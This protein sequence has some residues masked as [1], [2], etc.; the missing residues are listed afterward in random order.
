[1]QSTG[2]F[3]AMNLSKFCNFYRQ[4]SITLKAMLEDLHM[5][6]AIHGLAAKHALI[7]RLGGE[8][9]LTE[10]FPMARLLP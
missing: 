2:R 9:V 10:L 4:F 3:V 8:H 6:W 7:G 1:M 5:P